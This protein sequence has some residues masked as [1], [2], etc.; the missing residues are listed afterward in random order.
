[1]GTQLVTKWV[2]ADK[3]YARG[4]Q[5]YLD[6]CKAI[7]QLYAQGTATQEEIGARYD[8]NNVR[9]SEAI[10]IAGSDRIYFKSKTELPRNKQVLYLLTTLPDKEFEE[11]CKP[12]TTQAIILEVKNRLKAPIPIK[13]LPPPM[14]RPP[15]PGVEGTKPGEYR[16]FDDEG[17]C[18]YADTA[19]SGPG[20]IVNNRQVSEDWIRQE[21]YDFLDMD[22]LTTIK[23]IKM[24]F[25]QAYH[26]ESGKVAKDSTY[27]AAV[28]S[29]ITNLET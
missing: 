2:E 7:A 8:T 25:S 5:A 9:I 20:R 22:N 27:M 15:C 6:W 19:H 14:Q 13:H 3:A 4:Q 12:T 11:Y 16:W 28:N 24:L 26:P 18:E 21:M 10:A 1:M 23:L 29:H 17:W